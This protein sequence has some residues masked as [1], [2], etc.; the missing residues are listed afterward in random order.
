[1]TPLTSFFLP[2]GVSADFFL[3]F[4]ESAGLAGD[5][6]D[7]SVFPS[8]LSPFLLS[9]LSSFF[10]PPFLS[11]LVPSLLLSSDLLPCFPSGLIDFLPSSFL[12]D[13]LSSPGFLSF[14]SFASY[15]LVSSF[16]E[17][18]SFLPSLIF[19]SCFSCFSSFL[20]DFLS[21]LSLSASFPLSWNQLSC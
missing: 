8:F 3:S 7:F 6:S 5:L 13:F 12:S 19:A 21:Y 15:F 2:S 20:T 11:A 10:S 17:S 14:L 18:T 16:F 4:P 9:L 1:V